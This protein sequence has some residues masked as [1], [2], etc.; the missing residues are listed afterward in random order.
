MSDAMRSNMNWKR[1]KVYKVVALS[2]VTLFGVAGAA[3][4]ATN[5]FSSRETESG[6]RAGN[7]SVV[8]DATA[9]GT[10]AL[11]VWASTDEFM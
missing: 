8:T 9:S 5:V 7:V 11:E 4:A 2:L 1:H 6:T 3:Y 10:S